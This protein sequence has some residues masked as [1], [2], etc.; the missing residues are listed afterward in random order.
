MKET[1]IFEKPKSMIDVTT[2]YCPGCTHGVAHRLVAEVI[3]ELG[4]HHVIGLLAITSSLRSIAAAGSA[5]HRRARSLLGD[6]PYARR[7]QRRR[8]RRS[9]MGRP[10]RS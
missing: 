4:I 1:K 6:E 5:W 7:R 8:P 2:H 9:G 10:C 3:D